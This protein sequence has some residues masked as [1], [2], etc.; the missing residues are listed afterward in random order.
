M[1]P[2]MLEITQP[3]MDNAVQILVPEDEI[4]LENVK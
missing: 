4:V 2:E 1:P 3:F